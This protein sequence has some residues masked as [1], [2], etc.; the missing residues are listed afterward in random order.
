VALTRWT[1][2][3][4]SW[5]GR[6]AHAVLVAVGGN[7]CGRRRL[8]DTIKENPLQRFAAAWWVFMSVMITGDNER[9]ARTVCR[10]SGA[11]RGRPGV[12]P[13][14]GK[15]FAAIR[16]ANSGKKVGNYVRH[17]VRRTHQM[18][19]PA[20][21]QSQMWALPLRWEPMSAIDAADVAL[22]RWRT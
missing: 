15:M 21:K 13:A 14:K 7:A 17:L 2:I 12:A 22:V 19:A 5:R 16:T 10:G 6:V 18:N 1:V 20:L 9:A 4:M 3:L 8:A 11:S